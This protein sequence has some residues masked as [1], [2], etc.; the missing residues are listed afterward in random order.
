MK[1][2]WLFLVSWHN[3]LVREMEKICLCVMQPG[4]AGPDSHLL[5][6]SVGSEGAERHH[7]SR[8]KSLA[9]TGG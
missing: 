6:D 3:Y 1:P 2:D 8:G 7:G 5:V 9:S 4:R